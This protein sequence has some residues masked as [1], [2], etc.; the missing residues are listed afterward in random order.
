MTCSRQECLCAKRNWTLPKRCLIGQPF[1][2]NLVEVFEDFE[3]TAKARKHSAE[4]TE[5]AILKI[6]ARR[7]DAKIRLERTRAQLSNFER[8]W[9]G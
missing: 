2:E 7:L 3:E 6:K 4:G 9:N 1:W 8:E 5:T